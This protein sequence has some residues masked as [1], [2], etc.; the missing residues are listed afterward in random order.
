MDLLDIPIGMNKYRLDIARLV[1]KVTDYRDL[2]VEEELPRK[3]DA[4]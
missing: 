3:L 2:A 1:R 4:E